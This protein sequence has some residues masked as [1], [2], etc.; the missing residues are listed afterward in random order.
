LTIILIKFQFVLANSTEKESLLAMKLLRLA[1]PR[2][3]L[4]SK[5]NR[6]Y[7]CYFG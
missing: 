3:G 7:W 5:S 6:L 1:I 2:S 4:F